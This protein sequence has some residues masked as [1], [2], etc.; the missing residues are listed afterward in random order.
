MYKTQEWMKDSVLSHFPVK[1]IGAAIFRSLNPQ[2]GGD[3][4]SGK[5]DGEV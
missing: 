5:C 1:G 2:A 3:E 4:G